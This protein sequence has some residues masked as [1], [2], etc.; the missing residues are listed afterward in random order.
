MG[1][2]VVLA[3]VVWC[4]DGKVCYNVELII[5]F[6]IDNDYWINKSLKIIK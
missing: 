4:S 5:F 1:C 2:G 6:R 3:V